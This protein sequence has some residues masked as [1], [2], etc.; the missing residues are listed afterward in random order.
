MQ[1][2]IKDIFANS[3][4]PSIVR[5]VC[6]ILR[7]ALQDPG[8]SHYVSRHGSATTLNTIDDGPIGPGRTHILALEELGM[9]GLANSFTFLPPNKG[10]S[11]KVIKWIPTLVT[12]ILAQDSPDLM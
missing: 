4:N 6:I 7:V 3:S 5:S 10:H 1:E 11:T 9:Q 12:L 8:R 2:R